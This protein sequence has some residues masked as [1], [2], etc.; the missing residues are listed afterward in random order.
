M[1]GSFRLSSNARWGAL[2]QL[3]NVRL[4]ESAT[5]APDG[6]IDMPN[7]SQNSN[8]TRPADLSTKCGRCGTTLVGPEWSENTTDGR[9][10]HIWQCP[11]CSHEF[12]TTDNVVEKTESDAELAEEFLS[13]LLVA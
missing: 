1:L 10:V 11:V 6:M 9:C 4:I 2:E 7:T 8:L 5:S 12:E 13:N 3:R